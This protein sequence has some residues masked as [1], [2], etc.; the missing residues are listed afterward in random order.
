VKIT[1]KQLKQII[2]EEL[3]RAIKEAPT[4]WEDA[5]ERAFTDIRQPTEE[6]SRQYINHIFA[7]AH[8]ALYDRNQREAAQLISGLKDSL[9]D[10]AMSDDLRAAVENYVKEAD[11]PSGLTS[12][13]YRTATD[14]LSKV[15]QKERNENAESKLGSRG[16][17]LEE[18]APKF[19]FREGD[20]VVHKQEPELGKG[21]VTARG[22]KNVSVRWSSPK[23]R[24]PFTGN[25]AAEVLKKA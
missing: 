1:K 15:L 10:Q 4:G 24:K 8:N 16:S 14:E 7:R 11:A 17:A 20:S 3:Q 23:G 21:K 19:G 22:A 12:S 18:T 2:K 13:S 6:R 5:G 9:R 25:H